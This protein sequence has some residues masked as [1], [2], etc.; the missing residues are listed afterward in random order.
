MVN[1]KHW[2]DC[3]ITNGGC[4]G[5]NLYGGRPSEGTCRRCDSYDGPARGLGDRISNALTAVGITKKPGCGCS[6]RQHTLNEKF[7]SGN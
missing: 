4:C 5:L 1:C 2:S 6:Q 7:P 3:G